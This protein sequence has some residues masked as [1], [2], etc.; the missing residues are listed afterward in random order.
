MVEAKKIKQI[1]VVLGMGGHTSQILR[2]VDSMEKSGEQNYSYSY[3][4]GHDDKTSEKKI[5]FSGQIYRM[6]NPRLMTQKSL[7]VVFFNMF[8]ATI[9]AFKVLWKTDA[10]VVISSGPALSIPLFWMAKLL[11]GCRTIFLESWVRWKSGS[12]TGK[13]VYKVT[14]LFL[15]QWKEM[16]EVYPK[17]VYGG[18]LS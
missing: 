1:L 3:L 7:F 14:D 9:D 6:K 10:D 2:L 16:K 4:L 12:A 17:S 8:P 11:F 15:V 5:K 18:R 13:L